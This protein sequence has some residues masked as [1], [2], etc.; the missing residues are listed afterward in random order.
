[1]IIIVMGV[2]GAGKTTIAR[3]L[4]D[5]LQWRFI[6]ADDFHSAANIAK[7][8]AGVPLSDEDRAPW[9][10]RVGAEIRASQ[11]DTVVA[12]SALRRVY[13]QELR[14]SASDVRFV[15]IALTVEAARQR[16]LKRRGHFVDERIIESQFATLEVP[17]AGEALTVDGRNSAAEIVSAIISEFGLK[18]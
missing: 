8:S 1:M 14:E 16:L 2:A 15:Y 13:R 6:D 17:D 5:R 10:A 11:S 18:E 4:A 12:C 7:M 3:A 9:L